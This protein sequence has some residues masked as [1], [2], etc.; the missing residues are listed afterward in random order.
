MEAGPIQFRQAQGP[1]HRPVTAKR[2]RHAFSALYGYAKNICHAT[3]ISSMSQLIQKET[4]AGYV[5]WCMNVRNVKGQTL[6]RNL[7]LIP[8]ALRHH[9]A[10]K[11]LDIDWF[12]PLLDRIPAEE[13]SEVK[14]RKAEKYLEYGAVESIP[15]KIRADR[16]AAEKK[17]TA[18]LAEL[19]M[20][21]LIMKWLVTLPWL[22]LNIRKMRI[23]GP[24]PTLFRAAIPPY[25]ELDKPDWVRQEEQ[26]N[27][28]AA[29]WQFRFSKD[30]T[31]TKH[32]VHALLPRQL[33]S[34]LEEYLKDFRPLLIGVSDPEPCS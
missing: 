15:D 19:V 2:L 16:A 34:L 31:K 29:F 23:G 14:K 8:A 17:G 26:K 32:P 13:E 21:E 6:Q 28:A 3:E 5:E 4:V 22:Q 30:E 10:H 12:K 33:I 24:T 1:T 20:D 9:P 27:P 18:A 7:R 25:S 11:S